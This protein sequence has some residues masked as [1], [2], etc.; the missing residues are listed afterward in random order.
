MCNDSCAQGRRNE[1]SMGEGGGG[2]GGADSDWKGRIQVSR[3]H[4]PPSSDFSS[5]FAHFILEI[6]EDLK[7]IANIKKVFFKNRDF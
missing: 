3:N 1:V 2:G 5:D 7:E 6:S 4:L